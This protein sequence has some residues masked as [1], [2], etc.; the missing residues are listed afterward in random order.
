VPDGKAEIIVG[1]GPGASSRVL[2]YN[3][4][5]KT[6]VIVK[7]INPFSSNF[8]GGISS[9]DVARVNGD[10]I[11]D[12]VVGAGQGFGSMVRVFDGRTGSL[13][14]TIRAYEGASRHAAV[15]AAFVDT[16]N[17]GIADTI[18]TAQGIGGST[19]EIRSFNPLTG[20]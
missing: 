13:L 11:P 5:P 2:V 20:A 15:H 1:N 8:T 19:R 10:A 4:Q 18:V 12:I 14:T 7:I 16:N 3:A 17:D 9:I 6:P